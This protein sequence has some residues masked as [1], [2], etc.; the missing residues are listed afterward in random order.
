MKIFFDTS[1]W[2]V[3]LAKLSFRH[4]TL[5]ILLESLADPAGVVIWAQDTIEGLAGE[6]FLESDVDALGYR[7]IWLD[8]SKILLP[9]YMKN[10]FGTLS[11]TAPPHKKVWKA[12]REHWGE[13]GDLLEEPFVT[14]WTELGIDEWIP[15]IG[16][17]RVGNQ[18]PEWYIKLMERAN[19]A[20]ACIIPR[21][22]P[23]SIKERISEFFAYRFRKAKQALNT[24]N[25][26]QWD[27]SINHAKVVVNETRRRLGKHTEQAV[28][29]SFT[30][31]MGN[32]HKTP[33]EP[34]GRFTPL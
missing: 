23:E 6:K 34:R 13:C 15:P 33:Y 9:S 8:R 26:D 17:E 3:D 32:N 7:A 18:T 16:T 27:W 25:A 28:Y 4:K 2:T 30:N 31:C 1:R 5:L 12:L 22:F 19:G 21:D 24:M 10:Q 29:D 20:S 14:R 11:R